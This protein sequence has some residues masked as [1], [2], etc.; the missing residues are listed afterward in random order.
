MVKVLLL[1]TLSISQGN[2]GK[3]VREGVYTVD[4]AGRGGTV[5]AEKCASCHGAHLDGTQGSAVEVDG[6]PLVGS[7]FIEKWR[8]DDLGELFK[9]IQNGMP[10][11]AADTV[12]DAA[13]VD[14]LAFILKSN[15]FPAGTAELTADLTAKIMLTGKD[16]PKPVPSLTPVLVAGCLTQTSATSWTLTAA[17]EPVRTHVPDEISIEEMAAAQHRAPGL[18]LFKL[19]NLEFAVPG[20]KPDDL[21]NHKVQV[22]GVVYR[23]PNNERINVTA[24]RSLA[25]TCSP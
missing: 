11:E 21:K 16:G 14:I 4:Q 6:P 25:A 24:M 5:F 2:A 8:E 1:L 13:K 17:S 22:K 19:P 15:D 12:S 18:L 23:Q 3:T 10:R 20:V 9:Y 7:A